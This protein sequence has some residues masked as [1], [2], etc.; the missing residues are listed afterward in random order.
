MKRVLA[1]VVVGCFA[2]G[3]ASEPK[4]RPPA[5]VPYEFL[6]NN[7][8][9]QHKPYQK[10]PP[11]YPRAAAALDQEGWVA[12]KYHIAANGVPFN[13][14][15]YKSSPEGVSDAASIAALNRWRY[16]AIAYPVSNCVHLDIYSLD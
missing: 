16:P 5:P 11:T 9:V 15:V 10:V 1:C 4:F 6:L 7:P 3:C 8:C 13:V 2:H 14:R 12:M